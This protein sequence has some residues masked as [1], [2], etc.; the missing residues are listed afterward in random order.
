MKKEKEEININ[1][2]I[3]FI[4]KNFT[5]R[6][7]YVIFYIFLLTIFNINILIIREYKYYCQ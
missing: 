4:K 7:Y 5:Y 1:F 2:K 3:F 6:N